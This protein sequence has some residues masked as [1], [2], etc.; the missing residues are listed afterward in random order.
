MMSTSKRDRIQI[1]M[2][3]TLLY[4]MVNWGRESDRLGPNALLIILLI[5]SVQQQREFGESKK[6][7]VDIL[8]TEMLEIVTFK[9]NSC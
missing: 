9:K 5:S 2:K 6:L 3:L 1:K 7:V 8:S 4:K